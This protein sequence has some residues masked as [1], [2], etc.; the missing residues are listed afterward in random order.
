MDTK[1][2]DTKERAAITADLSQ[3]ELHVGVVDLKSS[4]ASSDEE[5]LA[6][7]VNNQT[8]N[9]ETLWSAAE[10]F[11]IFT[12]HAPVRGICILW[13]CLIGTQPADSAGWRRKQCSK[14]SAAARR[15]LVSAIMSWG[16]LTVEPKDISTTS[17][18]DLCLFIRGTRLLNLC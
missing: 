17:V 15:W 2:L 3:H 6:A 9:Q 7:G 8:A 5:R 10:K 1:I 4:V 16:N 18:R 13:V 12:G 14:L 11:A